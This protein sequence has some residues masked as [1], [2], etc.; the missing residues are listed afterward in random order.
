MFPHTSV[1]KEGRNLGGGG[2]GGGGGGL[3]PVLVLQCSQATQ[4]LTRGVL[5]PHL[6]P[7]DSCF[8]RVKVCIM[9]LK[10]CLSLYADLGF[11]L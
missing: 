6:L 3:H 5:V 10:I 11:Q 4:H 8:V 2:G 1:L 9:R 7:A